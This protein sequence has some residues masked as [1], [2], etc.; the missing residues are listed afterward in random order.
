MLLD[1]AEF[2]D[3][4]RPA[5]AA[6][7]R[8][9]SFEPC[10]ALCA[11]LRDSVRAFADRY[12]VGDAEPLLLRVAEGL[13]FDRGFWRLLVGEVLLVAAAEL[14]ELQTSPRTLTWLLARDRYPQ[15]EGPRE[16]S[17]AVEQVHFGSRDLVFG[18]GYY[19]PDHAGYNDRDD[20]ARLAAYLDGIDGE[21][22]EVSDL[23]G[24]PH[25]AD[26]PDP[27]EELEFARQC[28]AGL[29][30]LYRRADA[31]GRVVVCEAG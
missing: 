1:A 19:R 17:A 5:L 4:I 18:G 30:D 6:S 27:E 12:H 28:L 10:R 22:W 7:W 9:R 8:R 26:D 20:V 23:A 24:C 29:R 31:G 15:G 3:S 16:R 14:P 13:P 25:L 2:H 21:A 11:S